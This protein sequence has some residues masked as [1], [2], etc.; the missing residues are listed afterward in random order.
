MMKSMMKRIHFK[1]SFN[2][3]DEEIVHD[4][5]SIDNNNNDDDDDKDDEI[6]NNDENNNNITYNSP[7]KRLI[8]T[9]QPSTSLNSDSSS[10]SPS[11]PINLAKAY[12]KPFHVDVASL[13]AFYTK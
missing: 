4:I 11:S 13:K 5:L 12:N 1:K 8:K 2:E 10:Q 3:N 9:I 6:D 7:Q